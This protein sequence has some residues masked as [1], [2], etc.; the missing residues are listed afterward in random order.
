MTC[1]LFKVLLGK[2]KNVMKGTLIDVY[3]ELKISA[4]NVEVFRDWQLWRV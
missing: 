4:K 2:Q 1:I 3:A